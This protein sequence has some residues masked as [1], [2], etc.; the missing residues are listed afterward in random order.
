MFPEDMTR[1]R[2]RSSKKVSK[3]ITITPSLLRSGWSDVDTSDKSIN[4]ITSYFKIIL[5][6]DNMILYDIS[7]PDSSSTM[8]FVLPW[9]PPKGS[10]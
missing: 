7:W 3:R 4:L 8:L 10:R 9:S 6:Q 1:V 5:N 2:R